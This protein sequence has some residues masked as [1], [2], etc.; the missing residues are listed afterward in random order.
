MQDDCSLTDCGSLCKSGPLFSPQRNVPIGLQKSQK[1][2]NLPDFSTDSL[3]MERCEDEEDDECWLL[4]EQT[5]GQADLSSGRGPSSLCRT[6]VTNYTLA[7]SSTSVGT[8]Q[9]L[10]YNE[11]GELTFNCFFYEFKKVIILRFECR[12][13]QFRLGAEPLVII[14]QRWRKNSPTAHSSMAGIENWTNNAMLAQPTITTFYSQE[15][16]ANE[17]H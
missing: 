13:E 16:S 15:D 10:D 1:G 14:R 11:P 6:N 4:Q 3:M 5:G 9:E 12:Y 17:C 7:W 8:D 2:C